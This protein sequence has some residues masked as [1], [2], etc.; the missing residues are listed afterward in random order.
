MNKKNIEG[1]AGLETWPKC[2][3][4]DYVKSKYESGF[5]IAKSIEADCTKYIWVTHH[6]VHTFPLPGKVRGNV[7]S[8]V[9]FSGSSNS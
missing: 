5:N 8:D 4:C 6:T 9:R 1:F 7:S 3:D 2:R